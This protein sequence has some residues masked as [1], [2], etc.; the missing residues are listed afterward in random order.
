MKRYC[1][2]KKR[3]VDG[4]KLEGFAIKF[5]YCTGGEFSSSE[6]KQSYFRKN[7]VYE[8]HEPQT[9]AHRTPKPT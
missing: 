2:G 6:A 9:A 1:G 3:V 8:A 7:A 4:E 5:G